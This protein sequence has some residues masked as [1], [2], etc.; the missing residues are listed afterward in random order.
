MKHFHEKMLTHKVTDLK[1]CRKTLKILISILL[2]LDWHEHLPQQDDVE[3]Q[4]MQAQFLGQLEIPS[5]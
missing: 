2:K 3:L 4:V 1:C 5:W